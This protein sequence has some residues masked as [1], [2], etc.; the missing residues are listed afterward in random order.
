MLGCS[1][2]ELQ[3]GL[4]IP[5]KVK[6][7]ACAGAQLAAQQQH[8]TST[9]VDNNNNDDGS[10]QQQRATSLQSAMLG[11]HAMQ[12]IPAEGDTPPKGKLSEQLQHQNGKQP[13]LTF[14]MYAS[15]IGVF[16]MRQ[17]YVCQ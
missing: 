13:V 17:V 7:S 2:T 10:K 1:H 8:N 11:V 6:M 3:G 12:L 9:N 15:T 14:I 4:N 16:C 5:H